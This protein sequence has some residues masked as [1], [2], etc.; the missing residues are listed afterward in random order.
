M[1]RCRKSAPAYSVLHAGGLLGA[2]S[3]QRALRLQHPHRVWWSCVSLRGGAKI[4][5]HI[6]KFYRVHIPLIQ[7]VYAL[8]LRLV[9]LRTE[10]R[11]RVHRCLPKRGDLR[12]RL[13]EGHIRYLATSGDAAVLG[14]DSVMTDTKHMFYLLSPLPD[15][16]DTCTFEPYYLYMSWE[17]EYYS[18]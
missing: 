12:Y 10:P 8:H 1:R 16:T 15:C 14:N 13:E 18:S 6:R 2:P 9:S 11:C 17:H 5:R 7:R 4:S 3:S